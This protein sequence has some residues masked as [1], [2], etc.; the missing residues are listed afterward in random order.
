MNNLK[1]NAQ[2]AVKWSA[3]LTFGNQCVSF[4]IS[5]IL[6]RL[7]TP[8][9]YGLVGTISIFIEI[10]GIFVTGGLSMALIRKIDR[11]QTDLATVF[12]YNTAVSILIYLVLYTSAPFIAS[13]FNEP[14]LTEITWI[15][16]LT[17]IT[18]ALGA[19]HGTLLHANMEFK[20]KLFSPFPSLLFPGLSA[21]F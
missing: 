11:T 3:I 15:S 18:G 8:S 4:L 12:Y 14:L 19:V 20:N 2:T 5:V 16:G 13:Y 10:S 9:D 6:A 1:Q 7:L 21:F 17:L